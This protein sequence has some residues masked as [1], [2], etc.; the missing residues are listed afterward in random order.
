MGDG[1]LPGTWFRANGKP[2][3]GRHD[4]RRRDGS[5][6]IRCPDRSPVCAR[7]QPAEPG[8]SSA[9]VARARVRLDGAAVRLPEERAITIASRLARGGARL[10][11]KIAD[12]NGASG[13]VY[14]PSAAVTLGR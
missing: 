9:Q 10:S 6:R 2:I 1:A 4:R 11:E 5:E 14:N 13:T 12:G 3:G 8:L 7:A